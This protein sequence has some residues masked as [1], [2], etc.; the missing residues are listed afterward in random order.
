MKIKGLIGLLLA[1]LPLLGQSPL[2]WKGQVSAWSN[3]NDHAHWPVWLGAH[4]LPQING[5]FKTG[6]DSRIHY[7]AAANLNGSMGCH[8]FDS[9]NQ[10][11]TLKTYRLWMSFS[12]VRFEMRA[13]LQ[14]IN[15]GSAS[16]IRPLMWFDR[17]DPRD[18]LKMTDGVWGLLSRY[19]FPNNANI[20][21]WL[22]YGNTDPK[23]WE[24]GATSRHH[25]EYGGRFQFPAG[26]GELAITCH[27]RVVD[28]SRGLGALLS[29]AETIPEDRVALDG[30]WD[31]GPGVWFEAVWLKKQRNMGDL[32]NQHMITL[33]MDHTL[34]L[35]N[36]LNAVMEHLIFSYNEKAFHFKEKVSFSSLSLSY[37]L[38]LNDHINAMFYYDWTHNGSYNLVTYRRYFNRLTL[39]A[40]AYVNPNDYKIPFSNSN[41][42]LFAGKGCQIMVVWNFS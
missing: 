10:H 14:K 23:T 20:W 11:G 9:I 13:G 19:Y 41:A 5:G 38:N 15:F 16:N 24:L 8:P 32:T 7:E 18:P 3:V 30:K 42:N 27:H 12:T 35:G 39:Y 26:K 1:G 25:P 29:M 22:L 17:V 40:M 31:L 21:L 34:G 37:P 4:F 33:G 2:A 28:T 36:G 6:N